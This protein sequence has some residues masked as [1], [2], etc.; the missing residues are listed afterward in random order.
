MRFRPL[1]AKS[2]FA[3]LVRRGIAAH[4]R[5]TVN[6][7]CEGRGQHYMVRALA[8]SDLTMIGTLTTDTHNRAVRLWLYAVAALV[9][10]MVLVGGATR[11]TESGLSITEWKPVMGVVPPLSQN[12]WQA[13][14]EKY[15]AIP[16]YREMNR[17]MTLDA[18]KTIYWWEWAHRL[19]GR[20]IGVAFLLPF[21]FF[22]WR[23][24]VAPSLRPR[25]WFI[26]GLGAL[27]GAVGWWMVASG[28]ADRVEVSQYRLATHLLLACLIYVAIIF[29][30]QRTDG[31]TAPLGTLPGRIRAAA[32]ALLVLVLAQ[33]YFGALVAGLRAGY[34]YNTWPLIDGALVPDAAR[35]FFDTP[36]WRNF[37]ENILTVQFDHRMLAYAIFVIALL[38]ALDVAGA[39]KDRGVR[40][41]AFVLF[42][43]ILL[44]MALGI[45]TL[46]WVVPVS[47]ALLHQA[48]AMLVLTAATVHAA[49]LKQQRVKRPLIPAQAGIQP[50][51]PLS[52]GRAG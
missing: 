8:T 9:L 13:E 44:Q 52:R 49:F 16:Q 19:L 27:Q 25:L 12:A 43:A 51:S 46:L 4:L 38:H 3:D 45:A 18:F 24:W 47:L 40:T 14:F 26:F 1:S 10:A 5:V 17:G 41:G 22:L 31:R 29:T 28:L 37:F 33:I 11:V 35:L 50:G 34:A 15:Q 2:A 21:L 23:G 42:A 36:L 32:V 20:L 6:K 48:V 30:A 39:V 7:R